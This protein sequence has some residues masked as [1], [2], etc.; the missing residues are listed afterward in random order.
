MLAFG[1]TAQQEPRSPAERPGDEQGTD[2]AQ[3]RCLLN[4]LL[5]APGVIAERQAVVR[6]REFLMDS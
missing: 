1:V 4:A 5:E 6:S 2:S 3:G